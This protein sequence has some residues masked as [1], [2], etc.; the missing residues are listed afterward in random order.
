MTGLQ[1]GDG[2]IG[3]SGLDRFEAGFLDEIHSIHTQDGFVFDDQ[4][5][6]FWHGVL[7]GATLSQ[8]PVAVVVASN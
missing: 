3:V 1:D 2:F 7:S 4:D 8:P 5:D 6:K